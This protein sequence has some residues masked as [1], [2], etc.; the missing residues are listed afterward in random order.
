MNGLGERTLSLVIALPVIIVA[1]LVSPWALF[2]VILGFYVMG[3]REIHALVRGLDARPQWLVSILGGA[4]L[5]IGVLGGVNAFLP[6]TMV[7]LLVAAALIMVTGETVG[8]SLG[9]FLTLWLAW[10]LGLVL[11][12]RLNGV[13]ISLGTFALIWSGDIVAYLVGSAFGRRRMVPRVSPAKTWE[14]SVAGLMASIAVGAL[15]APWFAISTIAGLALG[16]V[17][18]ILA[19]M[20][21]L[22]ESSLKRRA[23][24]KDSGTFLP[25]HGGMLDRIDSLLFGVVAVFYFLQL[26]IQSRIPGH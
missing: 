9:F 17:T 20:G 26:H 4:F 25:G 23:N 11:A 5:L 7:L 24:L 16:L 12:L 21:D 8:A 1:D 6:M 3:A 15:V 19:Q 22:F 2:V 18:G 14:G 10:P 13:A